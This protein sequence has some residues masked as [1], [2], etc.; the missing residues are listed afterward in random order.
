MQFRRARRRCILIRML[1]ILRL[2]LSKVYLLTGARA[3]LIDTGGL[4]DA[5]RVLRFV[6]ERPEK[7][8]RIVVTHGRWDRAHARAHGRFDLGADTA[9]RSDRRRPALLR[10]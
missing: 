3:V 1:H 10:R 8:A 6:R 4:S 7:L 2:P 9:T 5:Q